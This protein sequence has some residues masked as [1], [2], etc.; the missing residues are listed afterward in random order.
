LNNKASAIS[1][2]K[3]Y[4][5][6][7]KNKKIKLWELQI[8]CLDLRLTL[9]TETDT[10]VEV[11]HKT[12]FQPSTVPRKLDFVFILCTR[13]FVGRKNCMLF[14]VV[15]DKQSQADNSG[16]ILYAN[17]CLAAISYWKLLYMFGSNWPLSY[18]FINMLSCSWW[19]H[20][21]SYAKIRG[22]HESKVFCFSHCARNET[23]VGGKNQWDE[24]FTTNRN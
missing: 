14:N 5:S 11:A 12:Y 4:S 1:E 20:K 7:L 19:P 10:E 13:P 15:V 2:K 17:Q 24:L 8:Q 6:H 3:K 23:R 9:Q 21:I 22:T 18:P 16:F